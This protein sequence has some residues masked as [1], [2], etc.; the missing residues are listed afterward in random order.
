MRSKAIPFHVDTEVLVRACSGGVSTTW[1]L[2]LLSIAHP[3]RVVPSQ[4]RF[5]ALNGVT[6]MA[7]SSL[8]RMRAR[9]APSAYFSFPRPGNPAALSFSAPLSTGLTLRNVAWPF[10]RVRMTFHAFSFT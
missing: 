10:A 5:Q 1:L 8:N 6:V 2:R 4:W 7:V 3:A 9:T